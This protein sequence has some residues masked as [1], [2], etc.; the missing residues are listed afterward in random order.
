VRSEPAKTTRLAFTLFEV[1]AA[2]VVLGLAAPLL[3][4]ISIEGMQ[5]EGDASRRLAASLLA[6]RAL[7]EVESALALGA[8]P[9]V[10]REES[11]EGEFLLAV[12]VAPLDPAQLGIGELFAPAEAAPGA[13]APRA[14]PPAASAQAA[15]GLLLVSVR[16]AW[17]DGV[18]EREVT[19]TT[20]AYD[21]QAAVAALGAETPTP[22]PAGAER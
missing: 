20:F 9:A 13:P 11:A 16:V 17:S 15:L 14:A 18:F 19:R 21:A 4:R 5:Y 12:E 1:L 3:F 22:L 7:F 10:G 2:V 6:D 8:T